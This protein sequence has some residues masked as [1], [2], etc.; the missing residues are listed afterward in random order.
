MP[1]NKGTRRA[2]K[3]GA[4]TESTAR[5]VDTEGV[6]EGK[7][8]PEVE[9]EENECDGV[10]ERDDAKLSAVVDVLVQESIEWAQAREMNERAA[11]ITYAAQAIACPHLAV[12]S[13]KIQLAEPAAS[14]FQRAPVYFDLTSGAGSPRPEK[15]RVSSSKVEYFEYFER[16]GPPTTEYFETDTRRRM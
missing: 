8:E 2:R 6:E 5:V 13:G 12:A 14:Y 16:E 4:K 10:V 7:E 11:F 3:S 9:V 15:R 1:R